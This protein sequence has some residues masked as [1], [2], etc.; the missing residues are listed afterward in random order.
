MAANAAESE[1]R[2]RPDY[3]QLNNSVANGALVA[4]GILFG[5]GDFLKSINIVTQAGD[6]TDADC[7]AA[8][9]SSVTG[10]MHGFRSF[11]PNLWSRCTIGFMATT[12]A[13][14]NS[15][16]SST[17]ASTTW[18]GAWRKPAERTCWPTV[19]AWRETR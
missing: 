4:L 17:S 3:P 12:W 2:W 11:R 16:G 15:G 19:R 13:R 1:A 14:C 18:R 6:Y 5:E 7:N 8:N 10:A 9:V